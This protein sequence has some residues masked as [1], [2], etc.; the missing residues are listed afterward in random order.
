MVWWKKPYINRRDWLLENQAALKLTVDQLVMLLMID[1]L[2]QQHEIITLELLAERLAVEP[3]VA[4]TQIQ[5]LMRKSYLTIS[6]D[7]GRVIFDIDGIFE[8]GILY[9]HVNEDIFKVF[10]TEFGRLLSQN[11]LQ[12]LNAWLNQYDEE[13][14]VDA[15]RNAVIYKKVSMKYINSI[16]VNMKKERDGNGR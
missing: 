14:I 9:E 3:S 12:T 2:N 16:L 10:E 8:N 15:L 5:D 1:Y 4:D 6:V 11:E 7:Q 13:M